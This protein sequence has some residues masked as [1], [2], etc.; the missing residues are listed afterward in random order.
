MGFVNEIHEPPFFYGVSRPETERRIIPSTWRENGAGIFGRL[1]ESL[2][3]RAYVVSGF[4]A[5]NFSDGG[6][7]GG[8]QKGNH[9]LSE[10]LAFVTR[11]DWRPDLVPGLL[12]GGS[13]YLGDAGQ[14]VRLD[15][16][17]RLPDTRMFLGEVHA[18]Y[19]RGPLKMRGLFAW[20][21]LDDTAKLN[22]AL[23]SPRD[24][25]IAERMLGGY[26][27]AG[28]DVWP[29]FFGETGAR[30]EPFFRVEYVDTQNQVPSGYSRNGLN[31]YWLFTP[32]INFYPHP[33]V[34]L[35]LEYRNFETREGKRPQEIAVGVGFAF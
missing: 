18:Q 23:G 21:E 11:L 32:G 16:G 10:D 8:R 28:Y 20:T 25:P 27:E 13:V 9:A 22:A 17:T 3:Y 6:V 12:L 1:G 2:E 34:V 5:Q 14:D 24:E 31:R 4:N 33:N 26:V 15:S 29:L 30:L 35:K 19:Q 7:R